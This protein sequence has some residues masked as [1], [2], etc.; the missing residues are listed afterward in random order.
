MPWEIFERAAHGYEAWYTTP[1]GRRAAHADLNTLGTIAYCS[2]ASGTSG[3]RAAPDGA[4]GL[5]V[6]DG[7]VD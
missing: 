7:V 3:M 6:L 5:S 4:P 2:E 1:R